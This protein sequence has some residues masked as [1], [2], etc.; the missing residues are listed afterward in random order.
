MEASMAKDDKQ[1]TEQTDQV[2]QVDTAQ[3][4]R[5]IAEQTRTISEQNG[6]IYELTAELDKQQRTNA[7]L[8]N[9]IA[10][11][12]TAVLAT[13]GTHIRV[14]ALSNGYFR[15]GVQFSQVPQELEIA[16]LSKAQLAAIRGDDRLVVVDL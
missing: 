2:G 1:I 7:D 9:Q 8:K 15:G 4:Q 14:A 13:R 6:R 10:T 16:K 3:L 11:P 12:K 5:V